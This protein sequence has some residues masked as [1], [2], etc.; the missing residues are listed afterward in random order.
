QTWK[1]RDYLIVFGIP[2]VDIDERRRR[3]YLQRTTCWQF[4]D[5][6][7]RSNNFT[8]AMLVLYVLAR[9]PSQGY[10]YSAT[11]EKEA[12][13]CQDVITLSMNEGRVTTNKTIGRFGYWGL[14]AE[15]GMSRKSYFWFELALRL[16]PNTTY[17]SKGDDDMFLRVPQFLADLRTLPRY[18]IYW[19][20]IWSGVGPVQYE[21]MLGSCM[22]LSRD[23]VQQVVW[24]E[25]LRRLVYLP[26]SEDRK[27]DY[28]GFSMFHEDMMV[29]HVLHLSKYKGLVYV[30]EKVCRFHNLHGS[31]TK[32]RVGKKSVMV[33]HIKEKEYMKL[34]HR[35]GNDTTPI[36]KNYSRLNN[37][38][39]FDC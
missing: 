30:I 33:H 9:H 31:P 26:F 23:V 2:S 4:P 12:E 35:F 8:G 37:R 5:V 27:R 22:T 28:D 19:G 21:F 39:E 13:E 25:A 15:V 14:E 6:A 10:E 20:R 29:G 17:I 34:M 11:L 32:R 1:E 18:G 24:C 7:T 3:R 36:A 38:I 16:F